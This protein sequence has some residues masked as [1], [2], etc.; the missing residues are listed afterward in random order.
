MTGLI[1]SILI[2]PLTTQQQEKMR[3]MLMIV[4]KMRRREMKVDAN[5]NDNNSE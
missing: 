2:Q 5:S 1:V 4:E 3:K